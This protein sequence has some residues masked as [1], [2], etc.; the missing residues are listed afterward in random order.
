[1]PAIII[2]VVLFLPSRQAPEEL[3]FQPTFGGRPCAV[4]LSCSPYRW[5][6]VFDI[7]K[8]VTT[9]Q[10]L[11]FLVERR[12]IRFVAEECFDFVKDQVNWE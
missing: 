6:V 9:R 1:M 2:R 10:L 12:E 5:A 3:P 8:L 11:L 4:T 7:I